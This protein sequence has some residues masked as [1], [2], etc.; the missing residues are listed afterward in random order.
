MSVN[1]AHHVQRGHGD[2][3]AGHPRPVAPVNLVKISHL[4]LLVLLVEVVG[5]STVEQCLEL[6][7]GAPKGV[8]V[9]RVAR[10][11]RV[12]AELPECWLLVA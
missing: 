1:I 4:V 6:V 8:D 9:H 11:L 3:G 10:D 2:L 7:F 12:T 5:W